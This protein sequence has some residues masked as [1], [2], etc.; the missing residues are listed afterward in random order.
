MDAPLLNPVPVNR[1]VDSA[2]PL[3]ADEAEESDA[4]W[5]S[6]LAG[7]DLGEPLDR[8]RQA[9]LGTTSSKPE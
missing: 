1:E 9:I 7:D 6:Y 5:R 3:T 8:V 2:E 4:A